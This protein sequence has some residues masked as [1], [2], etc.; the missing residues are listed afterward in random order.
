MSIEQLS[1]IWPEWS[2]V[3]Q[4]GEGSFGK[5]YKVVREGH[6]ITEYAAVKVITIPQNPAELNSL[7]A[8]GYDETSA[9]SYF[10]SIVTD[11]VNEIKLM[12]T[13]KGTANIVS[14]EDYKVVE[15]TGEIGWDIYIRMELLTSFLDYTTGRK[16]SQDEVI[17]LGQDIYSALELCAQKKII[18]RDIKPENIFV[19][20]FG[21]FKLGDFGIARELEKTSGSMSAKGTYNYI[22][23]EVTKSRKYDATVDIY[24]LGLVL[25]KLLNNNR[26]PFIDPY[27]EKILYQDRKDAVDRRLSGELLPHPIDASPE[28]GNAVLIACHYDPTLRFRT[29][30]EFKQALEAVKNGTYEIVPYGVQKLNETSHL[31]DINETVT[32]RSVPVKV[33]GETKTRGVSQPTHQTIDDLNKF[34]NDNDKFDSN[35]LK[36]GLN[37]LVITSIVIVCV[38]ALII[39]IHPHLNRSP[40]GSEQEVI[41]IE[42][43]SQDAPTTPPYSTSS[44]VSTE[45]AYYQPEPEDD[46]SENETLLA[47]YRAYASLLDEKVR[48]HGFGI[49][50]TGS[51]N[52]LQGRGLLYANLIDFDNDGLPE[53]IIVY[54]TNDF[55]F[56]EIF[57]NYDYAVYGYHENLLLHD[58]GLLIGYREGGLFQ[59]ASDQ[60]GTNYFALLQGWSGGA[61]SHGSSESYSTVV[62]NNWVEVFSKSS[63]IDVDFLNDFL[64]IEEFILN[65]V[66]VSEQEFNNASVEDQLG[67]LRIY[68]LSYEDYAAQSTFDTVHEVIEYLQSRIA[69]LELILS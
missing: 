54:S 57:A 8:D 50:V 22:A 61:D 35:K 24:S 16:L 47:A 4:I 32:G 34:D 19:S 49:T 43:S 42:S 27:A 28:M 66:H 59:I 48:Q 10:E 46:N 9:R 45:A 44:P 3:E 6:G 13:M 60:H 69:E 40:S 30:T 17:K 5:V 51:F 2:V 65:G 58:T 15:R 11:F 41:T 37:F 67:S 39:I 56:P 29:A 64:V 55:V 62:D 52:N 20:S 26:L 7:R 53:L 63:S 12:V 33:L 23:P 38:I 31:I 21:D 36:L 1:T 14:V 68:G 25:Y 18:H